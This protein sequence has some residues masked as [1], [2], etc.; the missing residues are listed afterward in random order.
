MMAMTL[1]EVGNHIEKVEDHYKDFQMC[2]QIAIKA[3]EAARRHMMDTPPELMPD[4]DRETLKEIDEALEFC[5]TTPDH[6][7]IKC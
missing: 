5:R 4:Y 2:R 3:L 6:V 1:S 7:P